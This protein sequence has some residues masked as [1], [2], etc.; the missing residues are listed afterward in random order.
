MTADCLYARNA[1][2][3][4][5]KMA[6]KNILKIIT[7]GFDSTATNKESGLA[8]RI[9]EYGELADS[10]AVIVPGKKDEVIRVSDKALVYS[11]SAQ[12]ENSI[13]S[14]L[15]LLKRMYQLA[16]KLITTEGYNVISTQD[17][18]ELAFIGWLLKIKYNVGLNMQE[19]GDFFSETFWRNENFVNFIRFYLGQFLIRRADSVRVVSERIKVNLIENLGVDR[20]KIVN[21]PIIAEKNQASGESCLPEN[22][23]S[24]FTFL[25]IARF[26]KQKNLSLLI[27]AFSEASK[28]C[29]DAKLIIVGRGPLKDDMIAKAK[30][31]KM[32]NNI[33]FSDWTSDVVS[34]YRNADCFVLSSNYEGW[35]MVIMEAASFG[36]PIIMTDVGCANE[37]IKNNESGLIVPIGD[38]SKLSEAMIKIYNDKELKKNLGLSAKNTYLNYPLLSK[39]KRLALYQES[40]LKALPKI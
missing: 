37:V 29:P 31:V 6:K 36:L 4:N 9:K 5:K 21:V 34:L 28:K 8:M 17:P 40:W 2:I 33:I 24:N 39:E 22:K 38:K 35:G 12:S 7:F 13:I 3:S 23:K 15:S 18:F 14:R 30:E 11:V 19:H 10:Y 32:Q 16:G 25:A 1:V 20:K 26:V 27:E